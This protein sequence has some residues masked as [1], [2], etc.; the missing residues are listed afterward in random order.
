MLDLNRNQVII[1]ICK[2]FIV[3]AF[4]SPCLAQKESN[5]TESKHGLKHM[6]KNKNIDLSKEALSDIV[7]I[8]N[9]NKDSSESSNLHLAIKYSQESLEYLNSKYKTNGFNYLHDIDSNE[10]LKLY[11]LA[12]KTIIGYMDKPYILCSK[13]DLTANEIKKELKVNR[14]AAK[15]LNDYDRVKYYER[16]IKLCKTERD[17]NYLLKLYRY[18]SHKN[19]NYIN[20]FNKLFFDVMIED[21]VH[22]DY[23]YLYGGLNQHFIGNYFSFFISINSFNDGERFSKKQIENIVDL[24]TDK[25]QYL[26]DTTDENNYLFWND[27][28]LDEGITQ[29]STIALLNLLTWADKKNLNDSSNKVMKVLCQYDYQDYDIL[30]NKRIQAKVKCQ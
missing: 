28:V 1:F 18:N 3:V 5:N 23:S 24:V 17:V 27:G 8:I 19:K 2:L 26:H 4:A 21:Q 10:E 22:R 6:L 15:K 9:A 7:N 29:R 30:S 12:T 11:E 14:R 16:N 13:D 25:Y 20:K